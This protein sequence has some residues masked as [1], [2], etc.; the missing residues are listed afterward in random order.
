MTGFLSVDW[1]RREGIAML[2][3]CRRVSI[4]SFDL[5]ARA[6]TVGGNRGCGLLSDGNH[7]WWRELV[8]P[9]MEV[10]RARDSLR[11]KGEVSNECRGE[12]GLVLTSCK[13]WCLLQAFV[14]YASR[15]E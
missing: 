7:S 15:F 10:F 1:L 2:Y 9:R 12:R 3:A 14:M 11:I 4:S 8:A 5:S 6:R 13:R